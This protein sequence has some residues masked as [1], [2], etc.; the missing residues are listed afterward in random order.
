MKVPD[1]KLIFLNK[2][3]LNVPLSLI[4]ILLITLACGFIKNPLRDYSEKPFNSEEWLKGDAV[5]RGRM[6]TDI[7][8]K[9]ILEGKSK[10]SVLEMLGEPDKKQEIEGREVWLYY[11]EHSHKLPQKYFPVSFEGTEKTFAGK[12]KDGTI[13]I[14]VEE[15]IKYER[16]D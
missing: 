8:A 16:R 12:I 9:R 4:A 7:Y 15:E 5:E 11:V 6:F 14:L 13:S 10:E 1:R 3:F 2:R